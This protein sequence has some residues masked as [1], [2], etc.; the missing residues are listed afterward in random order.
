MIL[1]KA[2]LNYNAHNE[3]AWEHVPEDASQMVDLKALHI[4]SHR[5][6]LIAICI[7]IAA[8][9]AITLNAMEIIHL[10]SSLKR[11]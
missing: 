11:P 3:Q 7:I 8:K 2:K 9:S 5:C 4:E 6:D 1:G 10:P